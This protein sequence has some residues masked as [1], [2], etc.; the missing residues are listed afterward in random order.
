MRY[1]K[2]LSPLV[3]R[4]NVLKNRMESANSLP[5]FLQGPESFPADSV[6]THY[7]NRA[8]SGAAIVTCMGINNFSRGAGMPMDMDASHFPD[9]DLY[10]PP[11]QNYLMQLADAIHYYDAIAC[12]GINVPPHGGYPLLK[13]DGTME[14]L[15]IDN[16]MGPFPGSTPPQIEEFYEHCRAVI[17]GYDEETLSK[18]ADSYA[19]QC[20]LLKKLGF[21][22]VSI[23]LCYRGQLP[24]KFLSPVTNNRADQYGGTLENRARFPLMIL[25]RIREAV[26]SDTIIELLFSGEEE[27]GGYT[28]DDA[29]AF[30]KLAEPYADIVQVR[31][32]EADPNH[33]TGFNLE[34]TPFL[35]L[36]AYI[37]ESGLK[38]LVASVGGWQNPETAEKALAEGKID[39]ISMARAWIS[40]PNYGNLVYEG[41]G[42]DIVPCLRCNKCH[43]Q[44]LDGPFISV[45]S[46]NPL[47]GIE[48]RLT[49][50]LTPPGTA[51][52]VAVIGGGPAGM[53]AAIDLH[54]RGH[55]V[56]LYEATDALGGMIKHA[57]YVDFKWPLR[58][59]KAYLIRQ[60]EKRDIDVQ[61]NTT[62][63][64][65]LLDNQ[66]YDAVVAALGAVPALPPIPGADRENIVFA[67]DALMNPDSLG[68]RIVVIGGGEVGV[69]TGMA[70]AGKGREVTV[71]EMRNELAADSGMIHYRSM[72]QEAWEALPNFHGIVNARCTAIKDTEV[73]YVDS[74]GKEQAIT[75]DSVVISAG[76]KAKQ[77]EALA[78]YDVGEHLYLA[79][80]CKKP[81]TV[82]Q[83]MRSAFAVASEI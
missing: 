18:I 56:T 58:D 74:E 76:V 45:C 3:I 83:A 19:Q 54:D 8:K 69:E 17:A 5:H 50:L 29:V 75:A 4:G 67:V 55:K 78:F 9:L 15:K 44:K 64:P 26:G 34:E 30:L 73:C 21:D 22:M 42:E 23:H 70:L 48:H 49:H 31:A 28:R 35:D 2:L 79:G 12:M 7:A 36:A 25:E 33:P 38:M 46:V 53:K 39:I 82:Q 81:A 13:K 77:E 65:K 6:I 32:A 1:K 66:D 14:V 61:L 59:F 72:F 57:D 11:S 52:K 62:A 80:D 71:L 20:G 51:K 60:V 37:K 47:I 40:N 16:P 27:E 24:T 63:T 43:G 41:R 10:D 68:S